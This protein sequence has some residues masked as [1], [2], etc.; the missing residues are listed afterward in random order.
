VLPDNNRGSS[1]LQG[2]KEEKEEEEEEEA[3]RSKQEGLAYWIPFRKQR[4]LSSTFIFK[5]F[6]SG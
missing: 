2:Q 4:I 6:L 3:K 5:Y 1:A